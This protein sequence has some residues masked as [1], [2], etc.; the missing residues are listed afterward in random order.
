MIVAFE[1][2]QVRL[3]GRA[4]AFGGEADVFV[5]GVRQLVPI[6]CWN[7]SPRTEQVLYYKNGLSPGS[8]AL[9]VVARGTKNPYSQSTRVYVE[10]VQFSAESAA[11]GFPTGTGPTGSQRMIPGYPNRQDYCDAR[12]HL[13]HPGTEV[14]TRLAA[15][16]DTVAAC[17]WTNAVAEPITGT[18]DPELYRYGYHA[19]DFW[20][21]LTVAPGQYRVRL[22]WADTPETPWVER[23]G[24]WDTVARPT[25]VAINGTTVIEDLSVRKEVGTF[26]AYVREFEDIRPQNGIIEVRF[27]SNSG[28]EAMIQAIELL[29]V[30]TAP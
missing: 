7:P 5:D 30:V 2:N 11:S 27:K 8:H 17:W 23:E 29:P 24:K 9:K 1:G 19:R 16:R 13:W 18:A 28:H 12:G 25:T 6:D 26:K 21:N 15:G 10:A 3:I 4:D 14:V 20:V 22:H